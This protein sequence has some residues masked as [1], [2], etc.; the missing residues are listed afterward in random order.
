MLLLIGIHIVAHFLSSETTQKSKRRHVVS[1]HTFLCFYWVR[2]EN[3]NSIDDAHKNTR[4]NNFFIF[5][6]SFSMWNHMQEVSQLRH[7]EEEMTK[8]SCRE[9]C[10]TSICLITFLVVQFK[11]TRAKMGTEEGR[12]LPRTRILKVNIRGKGFQ[13]TKLI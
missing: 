12:R 2:F 7:R 4:G 3:G 13:S 1:F 6:C 9:N 10:E 5:L 8:W 11:N